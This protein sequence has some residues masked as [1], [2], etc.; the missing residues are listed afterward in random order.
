MDQQAVSQTPQNNNPKQPVTTKP[1]NPQSQNPYD[2]LPEEYYRFAVDMRAIWM[3][4]S[5]LCK[6]LN[7]TY[8]THFKEQSLRQWFMHDGICLK[9]LEYV[10]EERRIARVAA[11]KEAQ[12]HLK[13][14]AVSA[15]GI[16]HTA[17]DGKNV[18]DNQLSAAK[19]ILD[20]AGFPKQ[21][22]IEQSGEVNVPA[23]TET[24]NALKAIAESLRPKVSKSTPLK[25]PIKN[26]VPVTPMPPT[27]GQSGPK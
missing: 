11:L 7:T 18:N 19:D 5:V 23:I 8:D 21:T 6:E 26:P 15:I 20:R 1:E 10:K 22:K 13:E 12:D 2:A 4:Y 25:Q 17:I 16:L 3:P 24:A 27:G 9:A 14:A